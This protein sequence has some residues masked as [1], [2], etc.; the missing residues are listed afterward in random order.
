MIVKKI[1]V[2]FFIFYG[3]QIQCVQDDV[4]LF[5][6]A[7]ELFS[8]EHY[9]DAFNVFQRIENKS[10]A[11]FYN[12]GLCCLRQ[13]KKAEALLAFKRAEKK[14]LSYQEHT[15]VQSVT[16]FAHGK[17]SE[18][19]S[20]YD[21]IAVF[22][23]KSILS[24]PIL[25]FQLLILFGLIF[26]MVSWYRRW[27][28]KYKVSSCIALASWFLLYFMYCYKVDEITK[29]YAVVIKETTPIYSGPDSSFHKQFDLEQS[30]LVDIMAELNGFLKIKVDNHV[31]WIDSQSVELV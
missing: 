4:N 25:L 14:A 26:L 11:V 28:E 2:M 8:Q 12:M 24:T 21:Q 5:L 20:W 19:I 6:R 1:L 9:Q 13:N 30:Q 10:F 29:Q 18:D 27:Y 15:L 22:C 7:K 31:G 17:E 3:M 16:D 23:K